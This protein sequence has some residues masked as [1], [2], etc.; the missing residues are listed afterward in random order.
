MTALDGTWDARLDAAVATLAGEVERDGDF[1]FQ[2]VALVHGAPVLDVWGGPHLGRD[3]IIVPYSVTKTTIGIVIGLLV[4]RGLLDLDEAVAAYWPEFAAVGKG[5]V[6]VRQLLSHQAGLPQATPALSWAEVLDDHAA[7]ARLA[8]SSPLWHP[9]SAFGY[10][11]VTMG[12]LAAELVFRV[13]GSTM[14]QFFEAEVRAPHALDFHLGLPAD[15]E[16]RRVEVLPMVPPADLAGPLSLPS[17]IGRLALTPAGPPLD[18]AN[19]PASYR[20]GHPAGS[21]IGSARGI[22]RMLAL[23]VTGLEGVPPLLEART[24]QLLGQQQVHGFDEVLGQQDRAHSIVFQKPTF[25]YP[26]GGVRAIGHDGAQGC[27]GIVD[28]DTGVAFAYT[29]ARGPWP[30]G[31][32]PRAVALAAELAGIFAPGASA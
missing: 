17:L 1:S 22:A 18:F 27:L 25:G 28:P 19:D 15:Q 4:Q 10:H 9:G 8:A 16:H 20:F 14:Q 7:A 31:A 30:G 6:T 26:F 21:G 32:D 29:V 3:S 13:T 24:V 2:A 12:N 11:A 5:R 23:A